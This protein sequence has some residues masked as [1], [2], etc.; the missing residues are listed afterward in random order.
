MG[1]RE[2][3]GGREGEGGEGRGRE[4]REGGEGGGREGVERGGDKNERRTEEAEEGKGFNA[5][6]SDT[7][8]TCRT[9]SDTWHKTVKAL[10]STLVGLV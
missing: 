9:H 7:I 5:H 6:H 8:Y 4:G 10:V 1:R 3:G 2:E